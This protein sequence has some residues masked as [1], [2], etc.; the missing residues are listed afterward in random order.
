MITP[1]RKYILLLLVLL[2]L[3]V[4]QRPRVTVKGNLQ[5]AEDQKTIDISRFPIFGVSLSPIITLT[6][7]QLAHSSWH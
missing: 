5:N 4:L 7:C 6:L 3:M 1:S 2:A